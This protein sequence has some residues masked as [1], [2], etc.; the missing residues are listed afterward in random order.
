[1]GAR[2]LSAPVRGDRR[3]VKGCVI[4]QSARHLRPTTPVLANTLDEPFPPAPRRIGGGYP[5]QNIQT[6]A[7][8][9]A[10]PHLSGLADVTV[11]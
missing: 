10:H 7:R 6:N 2:A 11:G 5:R 3:P 1:V 9:P 8:E 4:S